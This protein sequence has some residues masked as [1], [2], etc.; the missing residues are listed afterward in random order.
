MTIFIAAIA[1]RNRAE[2]SVPTMSPKALKL[3]KWADSAV[4]AMQAAVRA[5]LE[6]LDLKGAL[7]TA[8]AMHTQRDHARFLVEEKGADYLFQV[9]DNQPKLLAVIKALPDEVFSP[10]HYEASRGHGRIEHRWVKVAKAPEG[11]D[12]PHA[13]QVVVVRRE[14]ADLGGQLI[15][16]EISYY[17]TSVGAD[18]GGAERLGR[19]VRGHWGIENKLHWVRDWS[20]DE[21]R[22]QLRTSRTARAM[23]TLRNLAI[24]VLRLAGVT[25][26]AAGLR[27]V[28]RDP[29]RAADLIG[30]ST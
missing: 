14:R 20:Y 13:A 26:I 1:N 7:V 6:G 12:F 25:N 8:D 22:H 19:H 3:S 23:A 28:S 30:A 18:R 9:K 29:R 24:S 10:E 27:W 15:S 4:A 5:L 11:V 21:D 16:A 2:T 17:I